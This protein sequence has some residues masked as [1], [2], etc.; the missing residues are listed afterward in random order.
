MLLLLLVHEKFFGVSKI[1]PQTLLR[2][3]IAVSTLPLQLVYAHTG[4]RGVDTLLSDFTMHVRCQ[5][6]FEIQLIARLL[7]AGTAV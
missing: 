4:V 3:V 2:A 7:G 1:V 5:A 6:C